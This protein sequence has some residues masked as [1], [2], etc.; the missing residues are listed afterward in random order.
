MQM[1]TDPNHYGVF[2][3]SFCNQHVV[4]FQTSSVTSVSGA[5][6]VCLDTSSGMNGNMAM[7]NTTTS[8]IVSTGS[9]NMS[10]EFSCQNLKYT[11]PLAVEWSYPELQLL[12][13]GLNKYANEPGIMKY[14]KIAATLPDKTVRDV[15][16][17]CQWMAARKEATRRRKPE[18]HY[19]GKKIKDRKDKMAEPSSW[20]TNPPVQTEMRCSS[21]MPANAKHNGF[22]SADSQ[23]D[24][25]MLNI[26]EENAKLL[27]Q[28][29]VNI[30]TSQVGLL[31]L[32]HNNIE[33]FHHA[34]RNINGLLQSM[35]QIPGIMSKMPPLPISVDERLASC[36]LPRAPMVNFLCF[37]YY[38]HSGALLIVNQY[39]SCEDTELKNAVWA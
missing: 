24:H 32:A 9:P 13:D 33:L 18:E 19:L 38:L 27:N 1:S 2:P 39:L 16:M 8:T 10:A 23:I 21:S 30:L 26:L 7:L 29:E 22:L 4:S 12:N 31:F 11:A 37:A 6:P 35:S 5:I 28:I 34:R 20:G 17:R 3:H 25:G 36:I 14:I 15:A